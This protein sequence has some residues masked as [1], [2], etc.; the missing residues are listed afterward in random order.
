MLIIQDPT[1]EESSYLLESILDAL[2]GAE[3]WRCL[4][5]CVC[6]RRPP[7]C[8][9]RRIPGRGA[10]FPCR[11]CDRHRRRYQCPCTR[12]PHAT[13]ER[14]SERHRPGVHE[15]PTRIAFPSEVLMVHARFRRATHN[16]LRQPDRGRIAGESGRCSVEQLDDADMTNVERTGVGRM[17]TDPCRC[18]LPLDNGEVQ[19][20]ARRNH[21][22][23]REGAAPAAHTRC[24]DDAASARGRTA[25]DATY[26]RQPAAV[27]IAEI[28]ASGNRWS[29]ANFQKDD[30]EN[31]FGA[32]AGRLS[33]PVNARRDHARLREE[34]TTRD[35]EEP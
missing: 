5:I 1:N 23:A 2:N 7:D 22:M 28:P 9:G 3:G 10:R 27:L 26:P 21:V 12:P 25:D 8:R 24:T 19:A 34:Q 18:L 6:C 16:R 32:R 31:F 30:Y 11:S 33:S 17:E 13:D 20:Q 29:T 4:R 35:R 15:S 14:L